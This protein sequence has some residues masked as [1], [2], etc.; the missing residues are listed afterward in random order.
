M[1][2]IIIVQ[3]LCGKFFLGPFHVW[4]QEEGEYKLIVATYWLWFGWLPFSSSA[5]QSMVSCMPVAPLLLKGRILPCNPSQLWQIAWPIKE[6]LFGSPQTR[7]PHVAVRPPLRSAFIP[8][9]T[10]PLGVQGSQRLWFLPQWTR[11]GKHKDCRQTGQ[12]ARALTERLLLNS[13]PWGHRGYVPRPR[14]Q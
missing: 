3:L 11:E 2:C 7:Q 6:K 4:P 12:L 14:L 8:P 10:P 13:L 1:K 9:E 5:S